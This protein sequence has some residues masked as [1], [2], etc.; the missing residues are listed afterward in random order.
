M[1]SNQPLPTNWPRFISLLGVGSIVYL[2]LSVLTHGL[3]SVANGTNS[4]P[5]EYAHWNTV[6]NTLPLPSSPTA[7]VFRLH[8]LSPF[9]RH[10]CRHL[11]RL[12]ECFHHAPAHGL[13]PSS[14]RRF[15]KQTNAP[16]LSPAP[17]NT[18]FGVTPGHSSRHSNDAVRLDVA[19]SSSSH[20]PRSDPAHATE[21]EQGA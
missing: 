13:D 2:S 20:L 4:K 10:N 17:Q 6:S 14:A 7:E 8:L 3:I 18:S 1:Y 5:V 19:H 15:K 16:T 9:C 21:D 12:P 11:I